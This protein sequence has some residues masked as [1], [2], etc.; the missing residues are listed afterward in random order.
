MPP[1]YAYWTILAGGLPTS[2]RA[3][4]RD[5]LLPT[6]K[7]L[8]QRHADAEL[9][10]FSGGRLW[11]S[12]EESRRG[13]GHRDRPR[14]KERF[15]ADRGD[16]RREEGFGTD[17]RGPDGPRGKDRFGSKR[18]DRRPG[19]LTAG[20]PDAR[21]RE[22]RPHGRDRFGPKRPDR[23]RG[24][25]PAPDRRESEGPRGKDG[26]GRARREEGVG[27]PAPRPERRGRDWRPGGDHRDPRQRFDDARKARNAENRKRKF[28]R[29]QLGTRQEQRARREPV[30]SVLHVV[31]FRPRGDVP[32]AEQRALAES[33]EQA[34]R[35]IP[36]VRSA[37]VGRRVRFGH[38]YEQHPQA[39]LPYAAILE[40]ADRE[41]LET[42]L[43]HEAHAE[44]ARRLFEVMEEGVIFDYE[45][46]DAHG[47][48]SWAGRWLR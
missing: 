17:R 12:Q 14:G 10:W 4:T 44:P 20:R 36:S 15:S 40:F 32:P 38:A 31:L 30:V 24:A 28:E 1:R 42:Y 5:E 8:K 19:P 23:D 37:R 41:S 11:N 25:F 43:R 7:R 13:H 39:D 29:R 46:I 47:S 27:G 22:G 2:F 16:D 35:A 6:F 3:A 34:L 48:A 18:D 9:K 26:A 45:I 33:F 21:R